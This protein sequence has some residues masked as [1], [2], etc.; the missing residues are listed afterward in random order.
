[1]IA[2]S[3][4]V[5]TSP[6]VRDRGAAAPGAGGVANARRSRNSAAS[7]RAR[8]AGVIGY[9]IGQAVLIVVF[10][11]PLLWVLSLSL[12]SAEETLATPPTLLPQAWAWSNYAYVL[13]TTPLGRYLVNSLVIVGLTVAGVLLLAVPAAYALSR[14][15]FPG[16]QAYRRGLLTAQLISPLV[17][18]VPLYQAFVATGLI[19]NYLGLILVY[20]AIIA[21]FI[22]WFLKTFLDTIP[23]ELDESA[24]VDGSSP[25]R[26][27]ISVIVPAAR[28]GIASAGILAGITAWSQFVVPFIFLD[29]IKL[30]PVSVGVVN[31]KA[32]AG[33]ITT[34]YVAAGSVM[35]IAPVI[36][37]F[38]L[39]QRHIVGALTA[40]AVKG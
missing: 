5:E 37:L 22:T 40:G 34:Q 6:S 29:D 23:R 12:K 17:I 26:T 32:T 2:V 31:L 3:S 25:L 35:A 24:A 28:P 36:I 4:T 8:V 39:L 27:L 19:N 38:I 30:F 1:V 10:A 9:Y 16:Y 14:Y 18:A 33:E 20:I 13:Q 7:G 21:P 15:I 11:F